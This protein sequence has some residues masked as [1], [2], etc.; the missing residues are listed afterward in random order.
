MWQWGVSYQQFGSV[1]RLNLSQEDSFKCVIPGPGGNNS[2]CEC[3]IDNVPCPCVVTV[4]SASTVRHREK[5]KNGVVGSQNWIHG[6]W[7]DESCEDHVKEKLFLWLEQHKWLRD[8]LYRPSDGA[9]ENL[10]V[11]HQNQK[12]ITGCQEFYYAD[13]VNRLAENYVNMGDKGSHTNILSYKF[14]LQLMP[15]SPK[16]DWYQY[17]W[18]EFH[19][20]LF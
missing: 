6:N 15:S 7:K 1:C 9:T 13:V 3:H 14:I 2:S 17:S 10:G 5:K 4:R 19:N 20:N 8:F 16:E 18:Q 12:S 11:A